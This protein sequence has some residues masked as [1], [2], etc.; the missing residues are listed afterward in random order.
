M[1]EKISPMAIMRVSMKNVVIS[2]PSAASLLVSVQT[3]GE[4]NN[5]RSEAMSILA[6]AISASSYSYCLQTKLLSSILHRGYRYEEMIGGAEISSVG[7][8]Q[9]RRLRPSFSNK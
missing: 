7:S 2:G 5:A 1:C 4:I 8:C 6:E 3:L 9:L